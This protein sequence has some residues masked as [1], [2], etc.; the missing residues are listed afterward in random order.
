MMSYPLAH[1][2][3]TNLLLLGKGVGATKTTPT[4]WET[5]RSI[6]RALVASWVLRYSEIVLRALHALGY[7]ETALRLGRASSTLKWVFS[8]G[9]N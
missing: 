4:A 5:T 3:R 7:T 8:D 1:L 9:P 6:C 2:M